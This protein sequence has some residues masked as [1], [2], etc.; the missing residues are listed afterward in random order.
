MSK[1]LCFGCVQAKFAAGTEWCQT[2][3]WND[4][5]YVNFGRECQQ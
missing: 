5:I 1:Q 2:T 3:R 4:F